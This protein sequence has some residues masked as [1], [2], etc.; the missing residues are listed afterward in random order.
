MFHKT[1]HQLTAL[2]KFFNQ[3][4]CTPLLKKII[5][6]LCKTLQSQLKNYSV[7]KTVVILSI[8]KI[9]HLKIEN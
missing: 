1:K 2:Y 9:K 5:V 7:E 4:Y 3:K 8:K 6:I